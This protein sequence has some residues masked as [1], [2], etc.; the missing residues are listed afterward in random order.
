MLCKVV[1]SIGVRCDILGSDVEG[2]RLQI[3][4]YG[5]DA[6]PSE[7]VWPIWAAPNERVF[8]TRFEAERY[9]RTLVLGVRVDESGTPSFEMA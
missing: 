7:R 6:P 1:G 5:L 9:G 8:N 4:T 2:Y 3:A